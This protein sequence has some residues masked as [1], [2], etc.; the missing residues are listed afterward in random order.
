MKNYWL[1]I[2]GIAVG[3]GISSLEQK[4]QDAAWYLV[5]GTLVVIGGLTLFKKNG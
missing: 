2:G 1:I 4:K 3:L 5:G